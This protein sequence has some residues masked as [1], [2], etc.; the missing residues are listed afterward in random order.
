VNWKFH[1]VTQCF[2]RLP[3]D[4]RMAYE[5]HAEVIERLL[6]HPDGIDQHCIVCVAASHLAVICHRRDQ[7]YNGNRDKH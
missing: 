4:A 2:F 7:K 6:H 5:Y 1:N 3:V